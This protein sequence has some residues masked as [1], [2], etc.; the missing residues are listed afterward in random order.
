MSLHSNSSSFGLLRRRGFLQGALAGSVA[1]CGFASAAESKKSSTKKP[2]QV[3][4]LWLGGGASQFETWD[5]K[6]GRAFGTGWRMPVACRRSLA[7]DASYPMLR[8]G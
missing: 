1:S 6:P 7:L 4:F 2:R 8:A 5:P 3:L